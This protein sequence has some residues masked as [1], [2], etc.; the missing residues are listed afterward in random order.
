MLYVPHWLLFVACLVLR[1]TCCV[2]FGCCV[3]CFSL[4][5][6]IC[7]LRRVQRLLRVVRCVLFDVCSLRFV[8]ACNALCVVRCLSC[9]VSC[10]MREV[11]RLLSNGL[12]TMIVCA[13]FVA[14]C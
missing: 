13:L 10:V 2:M 4:F 14:C 8:V 1:F 5:V 11:W 7:V 9:V 3:E 12:F 6:A